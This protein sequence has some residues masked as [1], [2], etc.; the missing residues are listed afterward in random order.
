VE[1]L[2][3]QL[4]ALLAQRPWS[5][6]DHVELY[7]RWCTTKKQQFGD[8]K[9]VLVALQRSQF[10]TVAHTDQL[11]RLL[12]EFTGNTS[13]D[14]E[15]PPALESNVAG[16]TSVADADETPDVDERTSHRI[17]VE[18]DTLHRLR[19]EILDWLTRDAVEKSQFADIP[20]KLRVDFASKLYN[21]AGLEYLFDTYLADAGK[22]ETACLMLCD[23][24]QCGQLNDQTGVW[25]TDQLLIQHAKELD[26]VCRKERGFDSVA[27][28]WRSIGRLVPWLYDDRN[29]T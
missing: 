18:V 2:R 29:G 3:Q 19:D 26:R 17:L 7:S 23:V 27:R 5:E 28:V 10:A 11:V 15:Q 13:A 25:W 8:I 24:D 22:Q 20:G 9:R 6:L 14:A 12:A 16:D 21:R 1:R 4:V